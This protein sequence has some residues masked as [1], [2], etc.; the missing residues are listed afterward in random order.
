MVCGI[1]FAAPDSL[2]TCG[3]WQPLSFSPD[4]DGIRS[5]KMGLFEPFWAFKMIS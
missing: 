3:L 5:E 2:A 4:R 1:V